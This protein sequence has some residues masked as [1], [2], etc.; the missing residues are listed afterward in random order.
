MRNGSPAFTLLAGYTGSLLFGWGIVTCAFDEKAS[1]IT[2]IITSPVWLPAAWFT[3]GLWPKLQIA[4]VIGWSIALWY[5]ELKK[6][7]W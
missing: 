7:T 3:V 6:C 1:K 4:I 5:S 2:Y